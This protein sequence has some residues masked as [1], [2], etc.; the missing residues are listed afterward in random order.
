MKF[1]DEFVFFLGE[2][3]ALQVR[4]EVVY[5]SEPAAFPTPEKAGGL[6]E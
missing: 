4:S 2:V 1:D 3:P 6:R 5:P